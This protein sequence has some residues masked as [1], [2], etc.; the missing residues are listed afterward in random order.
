MSEA[1]P[2]ASSVSLAVDNC[3]E[4]EGIEGLFQVRC[5]L[6]RSMPMPSV[7]PS[8]DGR[9]FLLAALFPLQSLRSGPSAQQL[10]S[11]Q[12]D[13]CLKAEDGHLPLSLHSSLQCSVLRGSG[14]VSQAAM[15]FPLSRLRPVLCPGWSLG[16]RAR[17][18]QSGQVPGRLVAQRIQVLGEWG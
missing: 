11:V 17:S 15:C 13:F 3:A 4:S 14:E 12:Q 2:L 9:S 1:Q 10:C 7:P 8:S 18:E 6:P 5:A 16:S